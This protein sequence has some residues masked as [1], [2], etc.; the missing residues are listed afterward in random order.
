MDALTLPLSNHLLVL[1]APHAAGTLML[2]LAARL[3]LNGNLRVLDGG[4]RFNI[5]PVA[6]TIRRYTAELTGALARIRLARAFTCYQ[7]AAMLAETPDDSVPT[8]VLDFL[9]TFYDE[10]VSLA[11]SQ[12]L[13][14]DCLLHLKRLSAHAPLVVSAK[15]PAPQCAER[16]ILAQLLQEHA[17]QCWTLEPLPAPAP[18]MLWD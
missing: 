12:R 7:M 17:S 15:P 5:Y 13:L 1:V 3:S 9:A 4:N 11:E 6:S 16:A 2:E 8:L 18:A 10:S 14:Q